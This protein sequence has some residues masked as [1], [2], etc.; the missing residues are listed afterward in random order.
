MICLTVIARNEARCIARCLDSAAPF[1]DKMVVVDTGSTDATARIARGCG[2]Q[3]ATYP[4]NDD[5]AAARNFALSQSDADWHLVLDADE[6]I[7]TGGACLRDAAAGPKFVG[8]V[9]VR[10]SFDDAGTVRYAGNWI[11]RFMPRGVSYRGRVHEQ[12]VH[13]LPV[14]RLPLLVGHD[15]YR[16]AQRA[17]KGDR[18]ARLLQL[19]L[20]ERPQEAYLV[21]QSGKESELAGD[22]AAALDAYERAR[23][24][25]CW[26]V[27]RSPSSEGST[28][29]PSAHEVARIQARHPWL[30][31]LA[32]R[33]VYCLRRT[34]RFDEARTG[35]DADQAFW[36]HSPD[37]HFALGDLL[38]DHAIA[39]PGRA[40]ELL[41]RIEA[42]WRHCL[43]LGE[44]PQLEGAV[45]GRGSFLAAH[46]LAV[47]YRLL[48]K[49]REAAQMDARAKKPGNGI[50]NRR[51]I[52]DTVGIEGLA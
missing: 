50:E 32:V 41:P 1:V 20:Q 6:W 35:C 15:G 29:N 10:S 48:G 40:G 11:S 7:E 37:Y 45:Q 5:F 23:A 12:V 38:L 9:N 21:Y 13:E 39:D 34:R 52:P 3:M 49:E 43:D 31:D 26:P 17:A 2:A 16:S 46:N 28:A 42:C 44:A 27:V 33:S 22:Y 51:S 19:A 24:L 18:N 47:M 4:W 36:R 25:L 14:R 8:Q 30:H